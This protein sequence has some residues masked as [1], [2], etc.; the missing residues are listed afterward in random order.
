VMAGASAKSCMSC[1]SG[2][3]GSEVPWEVKPLEPS[4]PH[5]VQIRRQ[6]KGGKAGSVCRKEDPRGLA[7]RQ[8]LDLELEIEDRVCRKQ[9]PDV[10]NTTLM[11]GSSPHASLD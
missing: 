10:V 3:V 9:K 1:K 4:S 2:A 7:A 11:G 5:G 6:P 8:V